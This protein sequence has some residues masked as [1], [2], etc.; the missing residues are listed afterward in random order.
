LFKFVEI[1]H[2][3]YGYKKRGIPSWDVSLSELFVMSY[4]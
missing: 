4:V 1:L 2:I 3:M